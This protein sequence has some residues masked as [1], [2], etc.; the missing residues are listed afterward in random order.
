MPKELEN[1]LK[2]Q[3]NK[4]HPEWSQ[5]RKDAYCYGVLRRTGWKPEREKK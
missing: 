2:R 5:E 3:V 4:K 1:R